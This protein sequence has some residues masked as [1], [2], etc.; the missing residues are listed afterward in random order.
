LSNTLDLPARCVSILA[1]QGMPHKRSRVANGHGDRLT[2][3]AVT[4]R[5]RFWKYGSGR[6]LRLSAMDAGRLIGPHMALAFRCTTHGIVASGQ[7]AQRLDRLGTAP[8]CP[9]P[10]ERTVEDGKRER[11]KCGKPLIRYEPKP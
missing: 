7:Y 2:P 3:G 9:E 8:T 5:S 6:R 1:A 11:G 10:V 4:Q